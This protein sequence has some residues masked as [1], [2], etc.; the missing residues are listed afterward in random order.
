MG[1]KVDRGAL[2]VVDAGGMRQRINGTHASND[3]PSTQRQQKEG[4]CHSSYTPR[5]Q[6]WPKHGITSYARFA[7]AAIKA[8]HPAARAILFRA[9]RRRTV[10][11]LSQI[12]SRHGT[13]ECD[14]MDATT[15]TGPTRRRQRTE[16]PILFG[17]H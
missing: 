17:T 6:W 10:G 11:T 7:R 13:E 9:R 5:G 15:R 12:R 14:H 3:M 2:H 1:C 16:K 8:A 4:V